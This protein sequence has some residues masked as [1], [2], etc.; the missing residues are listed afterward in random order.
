MKIKYKWFIEYTWFSAS[1]KAFSP[2]YVSSSNPVI[3]LMSR[4]DPVKSVRPLS[5]FLFF[6]CKTNLNLVFKR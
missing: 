6:F 3:V 2:S 4:A 5:L 1:R